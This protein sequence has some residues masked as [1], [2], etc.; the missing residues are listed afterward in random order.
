MRSKFTINSGTHCARV[1]VYDEICMQPSFILA[2]A[3]ETFKTNLA[4]YTINV[5]LLLLTRL[6]ILSLI[7]S[8]E[9][10]MS[11]LSKRLF[12]AILD[13]HYFFAILDLQFLTC[14]S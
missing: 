3:A 14:N 4:P 7:L 12:F 10:K 1:Y 6:K 9:K 11:K 2:T 13:L 5:L 8:R